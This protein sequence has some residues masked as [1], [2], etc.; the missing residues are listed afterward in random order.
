M[1]GW[2][3]EFY[4][5]EFYSIAE[6]AGVRVWDSDND[7]GGGAGADNLYLPSPFYFLLLLLYS[8]LLFYIFI[9]YLQLLLRWRAVLNVLHVFTQFSEDPYK[10]HNIVI[11]L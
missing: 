4:P 5:S 9:Y 10:V 2:A 6:Q 11:P 7:D 1:L 8:F 3:R